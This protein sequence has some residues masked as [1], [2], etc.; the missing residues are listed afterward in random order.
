MTSSVVSLS[1]CAAGAF[2]MVLTLVMFFISADVRAGELSDTVY[3][4]GD[5]PPAEGSLNAAIQRAISAGEISQKVFQLQLGGIYVLTET[6][7]VPQGE[8]LIIVAPEPGHTEATRPPQVRWSDTVSSALFNFRCF[9]DITLKNIWLLYARS[10][11]SQWGVS[12]Q[13]EDSPDSVKGQKAAFEGVIFDFSAIPFNASGAVGITAKHFKGTFRNCCFRNCV[14]AHYRYYGRALSFPFSSRGWHSDSV[15]FENCTFANIG[16]VYQQETGNYAD[17]VKFNHC[18]FLNVVMYPLESGWWK[19]L[20]VTNSAFFNT[21]MYGEMPAFAAGDGG[22]LRIDSLS[23]IG[24]DVPFSEQ[25]RRILFTHS[26]YGL[27]DWLRI[28]MHNNPA[29]EYWRQAGEDDLVPAPLPM[30]SPGTL[31]FFD[32]TTAGGAKVFPFMNRAALYDSANPGFLF[33]PTD[34]V[35]IKSFL[36][37]RWWG[38]SDTLWAFR[39]ELSIQGAWPLPENLVYTNPVLA[40]AGMGGFPLGDLYRWWPEKYQQWKSQ[41]QAENDTINKWLHYGFNSAVYVNEHPAPPGEFRLEQNY[42]NPFNPTTS[43][44]YAVPHVSHVELRVFNILGQ[45]IATLFEGMRQPGVHQVN[46]SGK[47]LTSGAYFYRMTADR[48]VETKRFMIVR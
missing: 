38:S 48:F 40:T 33:P 24:F 29:S 11:G 22:T 31:R 28:W 5:L 6:I 32:S 39:P 10:N 23:T 7:V 12:L 18:T 14:D 13:I 15:L 20:S 42:P 3:V 16:Y 8:H 41:E 47:G 19:Y 2:R 46:F 37:R 44:T 26:S 43:I 27:E 30:L 35:A 45:E 4:P 34:T 9:G 21:W 1:R 25:E 36:Y 17:Y